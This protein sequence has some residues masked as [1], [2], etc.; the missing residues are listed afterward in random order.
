M[1]IGLIADVLVT[2]IIG[3]GAIPWA[4]RSPQPDTAAFVDL[5]I[6]RCRAR[7]A[8]VRFG[9]EL[10][11]VQMAFY[12]SWIYQHNPHRPSR[13]TLFFSALSTLL[14]FAFLL[15]YRKRKLSEL[16][17]PLDLSEQPN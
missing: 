15:W 7:L 6:R 13:N 14:F 9:A 4:L 10:F 1:G 8:A 5:S 16:V 17:Y 11:V 2:V 12:L 3:G